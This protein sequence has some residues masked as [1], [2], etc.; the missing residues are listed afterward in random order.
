MNTI[1][2]DIC[3][4]AVA[5]SA[6]AD[7]KDKDR[8]VQAAANAMMLVWKARREGLLAFEKAAAVQPFAPHYLHQLTEI[9]TEGRDPE[10][11]LEI[12]AGGYWRQNPQGI[13]ALIRY[14]YIR[15]MLLAQQGADTR[16]VEEVLLSLLP[17]EWQQDFIE[18][19]RQE[20]K[21][22]EQMLQEKTEVQFAQ[23]HPSFQNKQLTEHLQALEMEIQR[24]SA[25]GMKRLLQST[26]VEAASVCLY[27]CGDEIREKILGCFSSTMRESLMQDIIWREK[28][29]EEKVMEEII[30]MRSILQ[31]LQKRGEILV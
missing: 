14:F 9:I 1:L 22:L 28:M 29:S 16:L 23:M 25:A 10:L 26:G 3:K 21:R 2:Y 11:V 5:K 4:D 30:K 13:N 24:L 18:E 12:A 27:A 20:K 31:E 19:A 17:E 15:S 8:L 7:E 6:S